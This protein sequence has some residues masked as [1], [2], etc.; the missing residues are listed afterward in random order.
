MVF[1]GHSDDKWQF[2]MG[3]GRLWKSNFAETFASV[4]FS[5]SEENGEFSTKCNV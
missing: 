3:A 5:L 4:G 2:P 1:R